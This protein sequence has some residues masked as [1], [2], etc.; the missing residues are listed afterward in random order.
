MI[1]H[2][3]VIRRELELYKSDLCGGEPALGPRQVREHSCGLD[4]DGHEEVG[5]RRQETRLV[6]AVVENVCEK[7]EEVICRAARKYGA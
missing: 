5:E 2:H 4:D 6:D 7:R 3:S 1:L